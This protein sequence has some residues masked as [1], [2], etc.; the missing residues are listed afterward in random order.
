M[1]NQRK[2]IR[3]T[4][5]Y[6]SLFI[7]STLKLSSGLTFFVSCLPDYMI[8]GFLDNG[9]HKILNEIIYQPFLNKP[10]PRQ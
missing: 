6:S 3:S 7:F 1:S 10:E 4:H 9:P 2:P 8:F 5:A